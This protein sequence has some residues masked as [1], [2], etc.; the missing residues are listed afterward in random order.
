MCPLAN[1][2]MLVV[3]FFFC[4][5]L[6]S[7]PPSL[8][9]DFRRC[10]GG[11]QG[12]GH[13]PKILWLR[14]ERGETL[15]DWTCRKLTGL[16]IA[17]SS[18]LWGYPFGI[19]PPQRAASFPRDQDV[20][21]RLGISET[22]QDIL[23]CLSGGVRSAATKAGRG[24]IPDHRHIFFPCAEASPAWLQLV[25]QKPLLTLPIRQSLCALAYHRRR[26]VTS[27]NFCSVWMSMFHPLATPF[28]P[29]RMVLWY[30]RY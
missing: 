6:R 7:W 16:R 3:L 27:T 10:S 24:S 19:P 5:L 25:H 21:E 15:A 26:L 17:S 4:F 11:H 18:F 28:S 14:L 30:R 8:A 23:L 12:R 22:W 20:L 13:L 9:S 1:W 29:Y 2:P